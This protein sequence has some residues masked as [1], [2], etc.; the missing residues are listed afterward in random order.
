MK[1]FEAQDGLSAGSLGSASSTGDIHLAN[2]TWKAFQLQVFTAECSLCEIIDQ[3]V[4]GFVTNDTQ[5]PILDSG[6]C[7][8][9]YNKLLLWKLSLPG[10]LM[11]ND[12]VLPTTYDFVALKLLAMFTSQSGPDFDGRNAA[13]LQTLHASSMISNLWIYR[14]LYTLKYEYWA[15]EHCSF[16]VHTLLPQMEEPAVHDTIAKAC[17]VLHEMGIQSGLSGRAAELLRDIEGTARIRGIRMPPYG[18]GSKSPEVDAMPT[19]VVNGARVFDGSRGE[20]IGDTDENG[21]AV[22]FDSTIGDV[23]QVQPC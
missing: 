18:K 2:Q 9:L 12:S 11:T 14:G 22:S 15:A 8:A 16:A 4:S 23:Q 5:R 17:C 21:C 1:T 13:S 19:F 3:F 7:T 10:G 6:R 20:L